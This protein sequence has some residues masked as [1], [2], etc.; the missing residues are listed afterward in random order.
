M[1][2]TPMNAE[3]NLEH[4]PVIPLHRRSPLRLWAAE[5]NLL[6]LPPGSAAFCR[7]Q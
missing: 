2:D 5:S 3:V 6:Q 1:Y 4:S 7:P